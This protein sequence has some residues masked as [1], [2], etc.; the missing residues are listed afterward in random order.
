MPKINRGQMMADAIFKIKSDFL[1][2]NEE[3]RLAFIENYSI[4]NNY[5]RVALMQA[6]R[7]MS[8]KEK[9]AYNAQL[10]KQTEKDTEQPGG[11]N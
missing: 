5:Q 2:M 7:Y 1:L 9:K 10:N 3:Q 6:K 8:A 4:L 11:P